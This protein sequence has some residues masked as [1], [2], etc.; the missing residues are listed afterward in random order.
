M[1]RR[2]LVT[3]D[4]LRPQDKVFKPSQNGN[5][6]WFHRLVR[7]PLT[8][9]S[10]LPVEA[11]L[12][13]EPGLAPPG[14]DVQ[15][16]DTPAF[17]AA[18]GAQ[19]DIEGWI[20][21]F[22]ALDL[23]RDAAAALAAPFREC[24]AVVGFEL[25]EL[26]KRL[27]TL[28]GVPWVDVNIHP[29]RFGPDVLFAIATDH[30]EILAR[31]LP[32]HAEDADFEPWA[33]LLAAT[34]VKMPPRRPVEEAVLL[35]GQTQVDRALIRDGRLLDLSHFGAALHGAIGP[36]ATVLY[37]PHPYNADGFGLH[38]VGLR[39]SR[40]RETRENVYVLLAQP[41]IRRVLGVSSSVVAE[42]RFFGKEGVFLGTP[43][44]RIAPSRAA[45]RP[46]LHASVVDAWLSADFW[47]D[48]LAPVLAV[49]ARD[50]RR[51]VLPPNALRT[52]LRQFWGWDEIFF[53]LPWDLA[54]TR[55]RERAG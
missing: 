10:G 51:P 24:A 29:Y 30:P 20:G 39:L 46:G 35:V 37:K 17:Y 22:D 25:T 41:G 11:L 12:W 4:L 27:L 54:Q 16:F 43:P 21:L 15:G 19:P 32:H 52:S 42:A 9:A 8:A 40:I 7:R 44:M 23:P 34:A 53:Q 31:L 1:A 36:E 49:T 13:D 2:I 50:G 18:A 45:L 47:R 3:G 5:I 14:G 28:V 26:Q 33:D 6:Q 38:H 55:V 48:L